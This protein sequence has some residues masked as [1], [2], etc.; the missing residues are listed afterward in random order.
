MILSKTCQS[1]CT[2]GS[3]SVA[4][5]DPTA[6]VDPSAAL[7]KAVVFFRVI[8]ILRTELEKSD[9]ESFSSPYFFPERNLKS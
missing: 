6:R 9:P 7:A 4:C 1:I 3:G 5:A 8:D 2:D